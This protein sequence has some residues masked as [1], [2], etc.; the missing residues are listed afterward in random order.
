M[1]ELGS[2]RWRAGAMTLLVAVGAAGGRGATSVRFG[3]A[4]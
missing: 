1:K 2:F 3:Q 4:P